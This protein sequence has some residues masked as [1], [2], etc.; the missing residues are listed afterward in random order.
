MGKRIKTKIID[1]GYD[2][3]GVG[4]TDGKIYFVNGAMVGEE[5][6]VECYQE[7]SKFGR[8]RLV[9]IINQSNLRQSAPCPY[10]GECGGCRYQHT[11]YQNEL[12][13][14]K[15]LFSRQLKKLG[16]QKESSVIPSPIQYHYRNKIKL[17]IK[18]GHIG[19]KKRKSNDLIE[20]QQCLICKEQINEAIPKINLFIKQ[21]SECFS[22]VI[23]SYIGDRGN[24]VLYKTCS[25]TI[26]YQNLISS[27]AEKFNIC[28]VY[29]SQT[30]IVYKK[31]V[32]KETLAIKYHIHANSF[33]QVNEQVM[34]EL[35]NKVLGLVTGEKILNCYSGGGLLSA[36]LCQSGKMVTAIELGQKEH[37]EAEQLKSLNDFKFMQNIQGDCGKI[38]DQLDDNFDTIIVDPPRAGMDDLMVKNLKNKDFKRLIYISCD[39][40][41][42]IRDIQRLKLKIGDVYMFDMFPRTGEYECL[43]I[44]DK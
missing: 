13:I 1:Y 22:H 44:L 34:L 28:E 15:I 8:A 40:A 31:A 36:L 14:K 4:K 24:I 3:E 30:S 16:Y 19:L 43:V 41:T 12:A 42:L 25:K 5:V 17:F 18:G 32:R 26:D 20:I 6:E 35:Y 27:L 10:Y 33:H 37:K 29:K 38:L 39:S 9:N 11:S 2:G 7:N 23:I 21:N